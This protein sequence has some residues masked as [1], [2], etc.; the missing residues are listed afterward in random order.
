MTQ[1]KKAKRAYEKDLES[2]KNINEL[3]W[4]YTDIAQDRNLDCTDLFS[5]IDSYKAKR[6][7]FEK[8][9]DKYSRATRPEC[10][11]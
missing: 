7:G 9:G 2:C 3:V 8:Q 5:L 1:S 10:R 11:K 4:I 6:A